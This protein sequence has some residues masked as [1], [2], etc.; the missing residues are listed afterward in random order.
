MKTLSDELAAVLRDHRAL[1]VIVLAYAV[2]TVAL[3][4]NLD[5]KVDAKIV[6]IGFFGSVL[7]GPIM[8][9]CGYSIYIML[10]IR[11]T[12]LTLYLFRSVRSYMTP[13]RLLHALPVLV[14]FP[15][16]ASSFTLFK[17]AIPMLHPFSWDRRLS[18]LD[19]TLHGGVQPWQWLLQW[20]HS[21]VLTAALNGAYHLWFF[22][23]FALLYWL[24]FTMDRP[25]LRHQ[26]LLSFVLSWILLGTVL[27]TLLSSVGPCFYGGVVD[28]SNP[29][30][31]LLGY[32]HESDRHIKVLALD[33]QEL[34]WSEYQDKSGLA[35]I[36]ISAMPS[37]HVATSVLMALTGWQINR[38]AGIAL[39][40]F[41][42]VI[43]VGSVHLGWH[44][45]VDGY[46]GAAGA[47]AIWLAVG[48]YLGRRDDGRPREGRP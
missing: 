42:A 16:F 43:M 39:S 45:A 24:A 9:L 36:G 38:A 29:Y 4:W 28:G 41:A 11:P 26:F 2:A 46:V 6:F 17:G 34:L 10:Y 22:I 44:Y 3:T 40:A 32:L 18:A 1:V 37:M 30:Q 20:I 13:A 12:R 8:A 21:P 31:P 33:V 15:V 25:R 14:L 27:A 35:S 7:A 48:R 19:S 5:L 47:A 23:M